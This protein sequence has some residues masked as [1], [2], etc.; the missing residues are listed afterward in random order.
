MAS[1]TTASSMGK[2]STINRTAHSERGFGW[3]ASES[4]GLTRNDYFDLR[5]F[6]EIIF[7]E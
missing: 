5:A 6:R 4:D 1:G 2:A 7:Y 3:K